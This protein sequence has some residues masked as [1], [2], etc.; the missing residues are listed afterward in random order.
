MQNYNDLTM[1]IGDDIVQRISDL[2][3]LANAFILHCLEEEGIVGLVPSHGAVLATLYREGPLP[4]KEICRHIR[5]DKSTLTV[6]VRKLED[7]GYV[8]RE[9][10]EKD[11]RITRV[12]LTEKGLASRY[13]L[14]RVS[15]RLRERVWGDASE[16]EK[17]TVCRALDRMIGRMDTGG[18]L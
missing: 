12:H 9:P 14:E 8:E 13:A 15:R 5:R 10:D 16:E 17:E 4:M 11:S 3:S 7:L 18:K 6:L 2:R 1:R